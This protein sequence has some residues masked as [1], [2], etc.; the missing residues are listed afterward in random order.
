MKKNY[1]FFFLLIAFHLQAQ[2]NLSLSTPYNSD[3]SNKGVMFNIV[4]GA[5]PITITS[6]DMNMIG[7]STGVFEI[8][9]KSGTTY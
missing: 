5:T 4:N 9:Y 8:Y 7:F 3:N 2:C 6:F 1:L